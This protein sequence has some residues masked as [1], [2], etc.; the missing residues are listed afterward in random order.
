[1]KPTIVHLLRLGTALLALASAL[2]LLS[3]AEGESARIKF[4]DPAKPG[5]LKFNLPWAEVTISGTDGD[6]VI[7]TSSLNRKKDKPSVDKDGF[8]RLDDEVSFELKERNNVVSVA[9]S[10]DRHGF[11]HGAEFRIQVPRKTNLSIRTQAGGDIAIRNID[12]EIDINSMNGEVSLTDIT[13]SAVVSTMN[14]EVTAIFSGAPVKPVSITT[15]NGEIDLRLP[16]D[17]KANLRMRTHNGSIR[18]NFPDT[19]LVAK[20]ERT[21]ASVDD[22]AA[23]H[24]T[25]REVAR[26]AREVAR[27]VTREVSRAVREAAREVAASEAA[28]S[29][30]ASDEPAIAPAAPMPPMPAIAG[31]SRKTITGT[32]NGGGVD[33]SLTSMNGT[34]TL[35][36]NP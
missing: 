9:I 7:V 8:R 25:V 28:A 10:G 14:G 6:E 11:A 13:N 36:R 31:F 21:A 26:A 24:P 5:T 34:I 22:G 2:P 27:E 32:L 16:A 29:D 20:T 17:A 33:I 19:A 1:M 18:T 23:V 35:R 4:S 3:A 15:M 30:D 12:G